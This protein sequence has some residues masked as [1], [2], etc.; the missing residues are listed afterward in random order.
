MN[1]Y[2]STKNVKMKN[3]FNTI[4]FTFLFMGISQAQKIDKSFFNE[5]NS[6]LKKT[7]SKGLVDYSQ[8]SSD[9]SLV[10]LIQKIETANL[11]GA[12]DNT[13]KA[14]FINAYNLN[15][16]HLVGKSYPT[17]SPMDIAGFFDRKKINVA[18]QKLTLNK[19]EKDNLLKPYRDSRFHFV[20]VCGAVG[21]P[22]ITNFAYT[23]DDL[24]VQLEMQTKIAMNNSSFLKVSGNK[25]EI[26]QIF[27]WYVGDFGGNKNRVL[28]FINKYRNTPISKSASVSYYQYDWALNDTAKKKASAE[29]VKAANASRYVVSSTIRKG[30][31][32][33]KIFNNL[34][35]QKT[36]S[37]GDLRDRSSFFTT[38]VNV[39]YG[40]N[41]RFN[42]GFA[43][44][45]RKVRNQ[46]LPSSAFEVFG[47][48]EIGTS[49]SGLTAFGPQIRY[50]PVP[51]WENFSIQ[52]SF[53]F[54]IGSNLAGQN[55]P[56]YIDWSGATW[57][58]QI[59]N[60]FPIGTN[61]SLFT[62]LDVLLE[63][64]GSF[65]NGHINRFSTPATLIFSYNPNSKTTIYTLGGF[66]PYWAADFDYFA[67]VGVGAK[68]Q[69]T[70]KLE[71]EL[72]YTNFTNE[73]LTDT[74]GQAATYN[75][76]IRFN[77]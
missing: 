1:G 45:F 70:P 74:G 13:K 34:Y 5:V 6:F 55:A 24:E 73:L 48:D 76:G 64:I 47:S 10:A 60:D 35:S 69:F 41:N 65:D 54:P 18:G 8:A 49:R 56:P 16:I 52:S 12:S 11:S 67:Q 51:S 37:N 29:G 4:V 2:L 32:E 26:S 43:T 38:L 17:E 23:P 36:G 66:S 9:A 53:V 46:S 33:V 3:L 44:R 75:L 22:P 14:F 19:L 31:F 7:V 28:E 50:A 57:N 71:L 68:Y 62:E 61:F 21:C 25:A 42:I 72:L 20:L 63:D 39:L 59:F 77:I 27:K 30:S 58:T 40:L 15:V